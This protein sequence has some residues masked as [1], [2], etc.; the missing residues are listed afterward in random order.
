MAVTKKQVI[1][2]IKKIALIILGSLMLSVATAIFYVPNNI[3]SGG[4]SGLGI[5]FQNALGWDPNLIITIA[6][7]SCFFVGFIFL[8]K[9][10][11]LKTLCSTIVYPIGNFVFTYIYSTICLYIVAL[12]EPGPAIISLK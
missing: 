10:F 8:G 4:M 11:A 3:V 5:I 9:K 7:W 6:T 12:H 2:Q 1:N